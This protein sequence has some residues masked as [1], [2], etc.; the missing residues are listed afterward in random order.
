MNLKPK[1]SL[2]QNFLFDNDILSKIVD[3]GNVSSK[4]VILEIGPGTGSLTE[5]I[6][7][8][9]PKKIYV[10]EKDKDLAKELDKKF[11]NK[12]E[13]INKDILECYNQFHFNKPLKVFGN[14]PYNISSKILTSFIKIDDLN[15]FFEIFIFIFQK[16]VAERIVAYENLKEYGRLS[17]LVSWKMKTKKIIDISP[18]KFFPQP[19]VWSS[20]VALYP[21]N[22]IHKLKKSKNLEHI[23]NIFFNQ[24]RKMIKKPMKL[25]FKNYEEI[26]KRLDIK[27]NLRPQNISKD[28]FIEICKFYENLIQ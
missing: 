20:L 27:L 22:N 10:V 3:V 26:A 2:G 28:K 19:K 5:K 17:V 11:G 14:L 23:T 21:K 6:L 16:E 18:D 13:I 12:V 1:K 25:L 15:K 4:D 24:R 8:K 7:Q 9:K